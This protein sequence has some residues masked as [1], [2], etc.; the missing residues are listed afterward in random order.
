MKAG[1]LK[2]QLVGYAIDEE[3]TINEI[4]KSPVIKA[5]VGNSVN[6]IITEGDADP[7]MIEILK[8]KLDKLLEEGINVEG[9]G[10]LPVAYINDKGELCFELGSGINDAR[11][12]DKGELELVIETENGDKTIILG[13]IKGRTPEFRLTEKILEIKYDDETSW[14]A[15][16]D[17]STIASSFDL[18]LNEETYFLEAQREVDGEWEPMVDLSALKLAHDHS[19]KEILD[20]F[21]EDIFKQAEDTIAKKHTHNN[22]NALNSITNEFISDTED[23]ISKKHEHENI[24]SLDK[25]GSEQINNINEI[26]T[27]KENIEKFSSSSKQ[28]VEGLFGGFS[29]HNKAKPIGVNSWIEGE[30]NCF[31]DITSSCANQEMSM[32]YLSVVITTNNKGTTTTTKIVLTPQDAQNITVVKTKLEEYPYLSIVFTDKPNKKYY[33][34]MSSLNPTSNTIEIYFTFVDGYDT[35]PIDANMTRNIQTLCGLPKTGDYSHAEGFNVIATGRGSHAEGYSTIA[36]GLAS[37]AEGGSTKA[38]GEY[39]HAEGAGTKATGNRSHAEG[40]S[41][42]ASGN[43]SHAEGNVTD[44]IG[45]YSHAEGSY[46]EAKGEASHAEGT[47]TTASGAHSHA[48][49]NNTT[50]IGDRSHAEGNNTTAIGVCSH[51]E[52]GGTIASGDYSH[53]QGIN[54]IEDTE[55]KYAHIVGNG[56]NRSNRSNAHT[57][58]WDGNAWYAGTI[59]GTGIILPSTTEGSTKRFLITVNDSGTLTATEIIEEATSE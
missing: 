5:I 50:A 4:A 2:I 28:L 25:I 12:N 57:L 18:R 39:S 31:D 51:A 6:G 40:G 53:V 47:H 30:A 10:A 20:K 33:I 52:G 29:T 41:T 19:N 58:D 44:A 22:I 8:A 42:D 35:F 38:T 1:E 34:K 27:I 13:K 3:G 45:D 17:F 14:A 32:P 48:E 59:E 24:D 21:T 56:G 16:V 36:S 37:H 54:N 7:S 23:A 15:L 49:G 43:W 9:G 55:G 26:P 46:A 11:I